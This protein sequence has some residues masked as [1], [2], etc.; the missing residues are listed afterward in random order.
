MFIKYVQK[1]VNLQRLINYR[2]QTKLASDDIVSGI[3]LPS[4]Y[5]RENYMF[6]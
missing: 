3:E 6:Y 4:V 2:Y 1:Y 5:V